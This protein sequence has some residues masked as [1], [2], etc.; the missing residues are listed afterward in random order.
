[1]MKIYGA[2]GRL[3]QLVGFCRRWL[4]VIR[5]KRE[6]RCNG[7]R[8]ALDLPALSIEQY[9]DFS[10]YYESRGNPRGNPDTDCLSII[11]ES[12]QCEPKVLRPGDDQRVNIA[13]NEFVAAGAPECGPNVSF[14]PSVSLIIPSL[15]SASVTLLPSNMNASFALD[16]TGLLVS[17][18][19]YS[20]E[21]C[22]HKFGTMGQVKKHRDQKHPSKPYHCGKPGCSRFSNQKDY[23]R[24]IESSQAHRTSS[25]PAYKCACGW[26]NFRWDKYK[27]HSQPCMRPPAL[28]PMASEV[29]LDVKT[30]GTDMKSLSLFME[31]E[32]ED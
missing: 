1:M 5:R 3:G 2:M 24:H 21:Q 28:L 25:S 32:T 14:Q 22:N 16:N 23:N 8:S 4:A 17:G 6:K 18:L 19:S 27:T 15:S 9:F 13:T 26:S 20:C 31:Q 30:H 7:L 11:R 10:G 29:D 12:D